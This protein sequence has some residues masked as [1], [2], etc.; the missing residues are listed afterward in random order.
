MEMDFVRIWTKPPAADRAEVWLDFDGTLTSQDVV[1]SLGA[2]L[3]RQAT[4][5]R[6]LEDAW[7]AGRIG[8]RDCFA[9]QFALVRVRRSS[10]MRFCT[11]CRSTRQRRGCWRCSQGIRSAD[12]DSQRRHRLVYRSH[13]SLAWLAAAARAQQHAGAH[14]R[15]LAARLPAFLR[16]LARSPRPTA[17]ARRWSGSAILGGS[18][19]TSATDAAISAPPGRPTF[20]LPKLRLPRISTRKGWSIFRSRRCT[21]FARAGSRVVA[22]E[23]PRRMMNTSKPTFAAASALGTEF[24]WCPIAPL[25]KPMRNS[26]R[27]CL[28]S[29]SPHCGFPSVSGKER[30]LSHFVADWGR[31]HGF[32][33]ICGRPMNRY[34]D[35]ARKI[36]S[37]SSAC[38][39]ADACVE[40]PGDP[41]LPSLLFNAHSDVVPVDP[42]GW[43][44][45]PWA[46][47]MDRWPGWLAAGHATTKAR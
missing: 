6:A 2:R 42:T 32:M 19:F 46:G 45:D 22:I 43:S 25:L 21:M 37:P 31:Q 36:R 33:S 29:C 5:W 38:R 41:E 4:Q 9:G 3:C 35:C 14:R 44:R 24:P 13:S 12:D 7:Q 20:G 28:T 11:P 30:E 39:P 23:G 26:K 15:D 17:N 16:Q 1:D 10:S 27:R 47:T 18:G 8:S 34:W 40:L